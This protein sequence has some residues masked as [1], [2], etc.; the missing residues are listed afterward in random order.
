MIHST[1]CLRISP[2]S[3]SRDAARRSVTALRRLEETW[4]SSVRLTHLT[5][6]GHRRETPL[7]PARARALRNFRILEKLSVDKY[8]RQISTDDN[9]KQNAVSPEISNVLFYRR[10]CLLIE[11]RNKCK[12][13]RL[14]LRYKLKV[15]IFK[16]DVYQRSIM[17]MLFNYPRI[18]HQFTRCVLLIR[19]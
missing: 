19:E 11:H 9:N 6:S 18:I 4:T 16:R 10:V 7:K 2:M 15:Q 8:C 17:S 13:I 3:C 12:L 14:I 1:S 5:L